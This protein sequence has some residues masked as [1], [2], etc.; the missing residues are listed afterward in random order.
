[1]IAFIQTHMKQKFSGTT[2]SEQQP[3]HQMHIYTF[4]TIELIEDKIGG[5]NGS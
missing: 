5:E 1:M 3:A 4:L 2:F